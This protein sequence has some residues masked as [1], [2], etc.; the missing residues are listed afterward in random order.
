M[1]VIT[2]IYI[3]L[4]K[5]MIKNESAEMKLK[6]LTEWFMILPQSHL[7]LLSGS[8]IFSQINSK[9]LPGT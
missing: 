9:E 3:Y 5:V 4:A 7:L 8:E 1:I 2:F 6:M